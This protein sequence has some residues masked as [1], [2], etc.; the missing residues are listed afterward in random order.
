MMEGIGKCRTKTPN[1]E[2]GAHFIMVIFLMH[3][4]ACSA[5]RSRLD[6]HAETPCRVTPVA[7]KRAC[8]LRFYNPRKQLLE[9]FLPS[10]SEEVD[11]TNTCSLEKSSSW[12]GHG[13][14]MLEEIDD[15]G[16][17]D[18]FSGQS[19]A[20]SNTGDAGP[21]PRHGGKQW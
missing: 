2:E 19:T 5:S 7:T 3:V 21:T 18:A 4:D 8:T 11:P 9:P 16:K 20:R 10:S 17:F 1:R 6:S 13:L 12:A 14:M 15:M